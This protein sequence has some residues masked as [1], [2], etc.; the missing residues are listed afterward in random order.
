MYFVFWKSFC[1]IAAE[2][3]ECY[4]LSQHIVAAWGAMARLV[5]YVYTYAR[6]SVI[7][8]TREPLFACQQREET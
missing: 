4:L 1:T 3:L 7:V 2:G 5:N 8:I 6:R